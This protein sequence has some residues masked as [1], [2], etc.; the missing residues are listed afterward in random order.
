[1]RELVLQRKTLL[2]HATPGVL[3]SPEGDHVCWTLEDKMREVAGEPVESW[4][5]AGETAIPVGTYQ[6]VINRSARFKKDLP[7]LLGVPGF[8]GIRIHSGNTHE[9]TEGCILVGRRLAYDTVLESRFA[10]LG[11]MTLLEDLLREE[12]VW[13]TVKNPE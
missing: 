13:V 7:L 9:D 12:E 4:K 8:S 11:V 6:V 2:A 1:M 3:F 5:V 10:M